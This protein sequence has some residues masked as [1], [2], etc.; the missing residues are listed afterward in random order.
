MVHLLTPIHC[1]VRSFCA[2][3][4][5]I[6]ENNFRL[7]VDKKPALQVPETTVSLELRKYQKELAT[8]VCCDSYPNTLVVSETNS[9]KTVV[10]VDAILK[11]LKKNPDESLKCVFITHRVSLCEQ[12][13]K[14][15]CKYVQKDLV[16]IC[17]GEV[18]PTQNIF[19]QKENEF[20]Q[21]F[22]AKKVLVFTAQTLLN[23]LTKG[24]LSIDQFKMLIFDEC[25]HTDGKHPYNMI[26]MIY[27][28]KKR[29]L[30]AKRESLAKMPQIIGLS[31]SPTVFEQKIVDKEDAEKCLSL[32][33]C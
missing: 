1:S 32:V 3:K 31:A 5:G 19:M 23:L 25:H 20:N 11:H 24:T 4:L 15:I 21:S 6:L 16:C 7:A 8:F 22:R 29:D 33:C 26:M 27:L 10:A 17:H 18:G 28:I 2:E 30:L 13:Y 12:Q 14:L 9:G